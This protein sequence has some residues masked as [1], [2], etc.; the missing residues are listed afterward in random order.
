MFCMNTFH[1]QAQNYRC[2][3]NNPKLLILFCNANDIVYVH[4]LENT[5]S[6]IF[7][8]YRK[9]AFRQQECIFLQILISCKRGSD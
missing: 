6:L 9:M 5:C 3:H 7:A 2:F 4:R 8:S 1:L